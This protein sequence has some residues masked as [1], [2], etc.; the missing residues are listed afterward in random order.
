MSTSRSE[1]NYR[2]RLLLTLRRNL[3]RKFLDIENAIRH[4]IKTFGIRLGKVSRG[5]FE[6]R[7]RELVADD[8]LVASLTD[9]ML[10]AR[11]VVA[12]VSILSA[13]GPL[14]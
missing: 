12:G 11:G 3:K 14:V 8:P 10:R 7:V 2:L 6:A 5:K 13:P 9:C 4:S 1:E